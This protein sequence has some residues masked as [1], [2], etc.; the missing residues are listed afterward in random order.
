MGQVICLAFE[1]DT[2]GRQFV[3]VDDVVWKVSGVED[4]EN[5]FDENGELIPEVQAA[6]SIFIEANKTDPKFAEEFC[7][8]LNF[9]WLDGLQD[10]IE[11]EF[12]LSGLEY[13]EDESEDEVPQSFYELP[14][15]EKLKR[16]KD[17]TA[18]GTSNLSES[19]FIFIDEQGNEI[20]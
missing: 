5:I 17:L 8:C 10:D 2:S 3:S 7:G 15:V 11:R 14:D 13:E 18:W 12:D 6:I 4:M 16:L 9:D 1:P 20:E 19:N